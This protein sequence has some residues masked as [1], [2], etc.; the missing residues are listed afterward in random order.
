MQQINRRQL[1]K[2]GAITFAAPVIIPASALGKDGH[3]NPSERITL[4]Q[5][6]FNWVQKKQTRL[7]TFRSEIAPVTSR[8]SSDVAPFSWAV[9]RPSPEER[10]Y[11]L[12]LR[13]S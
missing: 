11:L 2:A 7:L 1:I 3:V 8:E 5:I 10:N 9:R 6:G 12:I 4:G 13:R